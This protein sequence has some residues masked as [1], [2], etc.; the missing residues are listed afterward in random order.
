LSRPRELRAQRSSCRTYTADTITLELKRRVFNRDEQTF[1]REAAVRVVPSAPT[2]HGSGM[3]RSSR[4]ARELGLTSA[5][6]T[7]NHR[8]KAQSTL[9]RDLAVTSL[10]KSPHS[11]NVHLPPFA[12][13][14]RLVRPAIISHRNGNSREI[15]D[16]V[17]A[18]P[19]GLVCHDLVLLKCTSTYPATPREQQ[20]PDGPAYAHRFGCEVDSG[21]YRWASELPWR[22]SLMVRP[23]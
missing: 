4:R 5:F 3:L 19:R 11:E 10:A 14:R 17:N 7:T 23:S 2:R 20:H 9:S 21:S 8:T 16:A 15:D 6:S 1:G 18:R 13:W 12:K 22:R